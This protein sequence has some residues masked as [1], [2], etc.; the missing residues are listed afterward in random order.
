[1][2]VIGCIA[3]V[4][5][6]GFI[7]SKS[8]GGNGGGEKS[9][10]GSGSRSVGSE[11]TSG[12]ISGSWED[13]V[14]AVCQPGGF[15]DGIDTQPG[16]VFGGA[17]GG[18][19]CMDLRVPRGRGPIYLTQWDSDF[20]MRNQMTLLGM[21]YASATNGDA[22]TTLSVRALPDA[23]AALEPLAQFGFTNTC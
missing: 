10:A 8:F 3:A 19:V 21:C 15:R 4:A 5:L 22:I 1:M 13:W 23:G 18:G 20:K 14:E 12:S 6:L 17:I 11:G 2:V 7:L 16:S 9:A